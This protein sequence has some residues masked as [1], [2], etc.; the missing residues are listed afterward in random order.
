V[1]VLRT[2]IIKSPKW[3]ESASLK[4]KNIFIAIKKYN[5][6][7]ISLY[8]LKIQKDTVTPPGIIKTPKTTRKHN[9]KKQ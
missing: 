5:G 4:N 6:H 7:K 3:I 9:L 8:S 2:G 1:D